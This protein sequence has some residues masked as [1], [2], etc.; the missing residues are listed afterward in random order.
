[1][2]RGVRGD[3]KSPGHHVR[4]LPATWEP[5][6][7][8]VPTS[9]PTTALSPSLPPPAGVHQV[10][11]PFWGGGISPRMPRA[12]LGLNPILPEQKQTHPPC[13]SKPGCNPNPAAQLPS[14]RRW[15]FS[16]WKGVTAEGTPL[17]VGLPWGA[18]TAQPHD[19]GRVGQLPLHAVLPDAVQDIG[20]EMD[21]QVAEEHDTVPVL[22]EGTD[23]S[24]RIRA[25]Q[26]W[27]RSQGESWFLSPSSPRPCPHQPA[28][29]PSAQSSPC[30]ADTGS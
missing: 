27:E 30:A 3:P 22:W 13:A 19:D 15:T 9:L 10:T 20:R 11:A 28:A 24:E 26:F 4:T 17:T 1:M 7:H 2:R 21:V 14:G 25:K 16:S 29:Q 8:P 6:E 5:Q 12:P 18:A 23:T